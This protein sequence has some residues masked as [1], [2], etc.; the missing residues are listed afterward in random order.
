[1]RCED[2][3][4]CAIR[5]RKSRKILVDNREGMLYDKCAWV[6]GFCLGVFAARPG[7]SGRRLAGTAC[8]SVW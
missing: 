8:G 4:M 6:R 2:E 5:S 7:T 1:M 3:N